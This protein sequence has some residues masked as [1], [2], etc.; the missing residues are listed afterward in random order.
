MENIFL[1]ITIVLSLAAFFSIIFRF[2]KQPPILAYILTGIIIGPF[3]QLQLG[4]HD[5]LKIMGEF[6]ITLLLF[7]LGLEMKVK[8]FKTIGK[9][10]I[11][12]GIG[13]LVLTLVS[14]FLLAQRFGFSQAASFYTA[15]A[16]TF[17]S[18]VIIVKILSDK[19][20]LNSL[21][22]KISIGFLL[23]QDFFAV[24]VLVLLSGLNVSFFQLQMIELDKLSIVA[25]KGLVLFLSII[26][27]S[28]AIL[29]K[30]VNVIAKSSETLFLFSVAWV[31]G[32]AAIVSS[33]SVGFSVEIG[34]FLAGIALANASENFQII[35]RMKALRDFFVTIFFVFL[36]MRM[37]FENIGSIVFPILVLSVFVILF[38]PL[39][40]MSVMGILGYRKRT[41][42]LTAVSMG[43][44]SEF[45]LVIIFLG[46]RIGHISNEI[47]SLITAV[48]IISF[49]ISAYLTAYASSLFKI[50]SSPLGF[51][52]KKETQKE[53]LGS[54]KE[55]LN[56]L[57]NHV[58]LI[59]A[60]KMGESILNALQDL[61]K[62]IVVV[63]FDPDIVEILRKKDLISVFGDIADID[64]QERVGLDKA[65]L[66]ISTISDPD[67][68][69]FLIKELNRNNKSAKVIVMAQDGEDAKTLYKAGAD[70]VALP[71]LSGGRHVAKI[72][73][74]DNLDE[75]A[76][77]KSK[78]LLDLA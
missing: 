76:S 47:V 31:F 58:V 57:K 53:N 73:K 43:Q 56:G 46:N 71:H 37:V 16:L 74:E 77:F 72:L 2:F 22:G 63:D 55:G 1:E 59:G 14:G 75:I 23:I 19:K 65:K 48:G 78:D 8:E 34:G 62:K 35:A 39:I 29:P 38:K 66:V 18:T 61:D 36:G 32:V 11:I 49:V 54:L 67:D 5:L 45:S 40:V 42:F 69:M 41:S 33:P 44:I 4:S 70:Y 60:S 51:F 30:I 15:I 21:Y 64:I 28:K 52:E 20:D 13:Q 6:G 27:L 26:F 50:L 9:T 68:N 25:I 7:M 17:S 10:V 12:L 24:L 3:G